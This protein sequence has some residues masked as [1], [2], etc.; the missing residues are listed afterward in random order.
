MAKSGKWLLEVERYVS[1]RAQLFRPRRETLEGE[2]AILRALSLAEEAE[3]SD[4]A[5]ML[6]RGGIMPE[7]CYEVV[8][9]GFSEA[10]LPDHIP[11]QRPSA[12]RARVEEQELTR[13]RD[14][15][16]ALQMKVEQ[17]RAQVN[18]LEQGQGP[19][20]LTAGGKSGGAQASPAPMR[21]DLAGCDLLADDTSHLAGR[22][23]LAEP[24][25]PP[26]ELKPFD[27]GTA[28]LHVAALDELMG[29]KP[30]FRPGTDDTM[31]GLLMIDESYFVSKLVRSADGECIGAVLVDA[32][33]LEN[34]GKAEGVKRVATA[35]VDALAKTAHTE[36]VFACDVE[37]LDPVELP[38][39][40]DVQKRVDLDDSLGSHILLIAK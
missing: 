1:V 19:K 25:A 24:E 15:M 33:T 2:G 6:M 34:L 40:F 38:W 26:A 5:R 29:G 21:P 30:K 9:G 23:L 12:E 37:A 16:M 35:M 13:M 28:E 3:L 27:V 10:A 32:A 20:Q 39:L 11:D 8:E 18:H 17:L 14:Q 4:A 7:R 36:E 31:P 22:D